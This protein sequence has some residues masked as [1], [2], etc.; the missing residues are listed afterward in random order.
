MI[1]FR[2]V[3]AALDP[4]FDPSRAKL[5]CAVHNGRHDPLDVFAAGDFETWQRGQT[6]R[7]FERDQVAAMI[8]LP[9]RDL[10]LFAG[11]YDAGDCRPGRGGEPPED[12]PWVYDLAERPGATALKGR[13]TLRFSRPSRQ[14]YLKLERWIDGVDLVALSPE[15]YAIG[16]FP[17]F[18]AVELTMPRLRGLARAQPADWRAALSSVSGVYLIVDGEGRQY[19]GSATGAGGVWAR[20]MD[21]AA[22]G[23]GGNRDMKALLA[24]EPEAAESYTFSLLET[25]DMH[26]GRDEI[27]AREMAWT[28]RLGSRAHGLNGTPSRRSAGTV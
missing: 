18:A 15:P 16:A 12:A 19:V 9:A 6:Q 1:P 3:L 26:V 17:G 10:W 2:A 13:A 21:Y 5:H 8:R 4:G 25:G 23:H 11:L 22:T 14:S 27:V 20:W 28:R 24:S 7:N